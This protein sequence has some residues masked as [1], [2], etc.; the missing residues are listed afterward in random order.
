[1]LVVADE[2]ACGVGG[3]SCLAGAREAKEEGSYSVCAGVGGAVHG[4][5]IA[6]GDDEIHHA[7][8]GLL[9]FA[10]VL[11]AADQDDAACKV[12]Q[13]EGLGVGSVALGNGLELRRGNDGE[14]GRV[15]GELRGAGPNKEL[16]H[17]KGVPGV[18][19]DDADGQTVVRVG[20]AIK[21]LHKK[22]A[23]AQ[24][25]GDAF[26]QGLE[27]LRRDGLVDFSPIDYRMR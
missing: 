18:L 13:D 10:G 7:E 21:V 16:A 14:L 17:E 2:A 5:Y 15:C 26:Q 23:L 25:R 11:G 4:K 3:E 6:V 22:L 27:A 20:A 19:G 24:V 1:M 12:G 9:H 8:D